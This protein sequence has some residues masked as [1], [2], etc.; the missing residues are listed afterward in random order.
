MED[1]HVRAWKEETKKEK[2]R[3]GEA[4]CNCKLHEEQGEKRYCKS[5]HSYIPL[6]SEET[7]MVAKILLGIENVVIYGNILYVERCKKEKK[8]PNQ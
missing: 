3:G 2:R 4:N 7:K 5:V 1:I 6:S 8:T